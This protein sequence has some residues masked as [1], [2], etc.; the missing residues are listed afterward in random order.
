MTSW[1][2]TVLALLIGIAGW[3]YTFYSR[4]AHKLAGIEADHANLRRIR[5]RRVNGVAM[6]VLAALIYVGTHGI[7]PDA[8]PR[9]FVTLWLV[10]FVLLLIIV[11]LALLDIR[12]TVALRAQRRKNRRE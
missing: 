10:I 12:L 9:Q 8:R 6:I 3:Y 5:L 2:S 4:A 11:L 1:P 7:D